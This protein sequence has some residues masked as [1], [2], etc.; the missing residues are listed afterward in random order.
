MAENLQR[1]AVRA[2]LDYLE[3]KPENWTHPGT[4]P[5][6]HRNGTVS[7]HITVAQRATLVQALQL[8]NKETT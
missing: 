2:L 8:L 4:E 6:G 3:G 7:L 1:E 5:R